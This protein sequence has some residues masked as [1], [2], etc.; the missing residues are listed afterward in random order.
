MTAISRNVNSVQKTHENRF[1]GAWVWERNLNFNDQAMLPAARR[2]YRGQNN[3]W[4]IHV[5]QPYC[6]GAIANARPWIRD[7]H[8]F[9][10]AVLCDPQNGSFICTK[11]LR[12]TTQNCSLALSSQVFCIYLRQAVLKIRL[13]TIQ[14]GNE[15]CSCLTT[16]I[17]WEINF[18]PSTICIHRKPFTLRN[19]NRPSETQTNELHRAQCNN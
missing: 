11:P 4:Q 3:W 15:K 9:Q 5:N 13:E 10:V 6:V 2:L 1:R 18:S 8:R 17:M 19:K 12:L 7:R 16:Q 14:N